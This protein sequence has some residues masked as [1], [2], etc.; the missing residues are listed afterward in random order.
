MSRRMLGLAALALAGC[1][2]LAGAGRPPET[3]LLARADALAAEGRYQDALE[4]YD[5]WLRQHPDGVEARR[6][7]VSRETIAALVDARGEID[8]L[9]RQLDEVARLRNQLAAR[10]SEL[11]RARAELAAARDGGEA[12]RLRGELAARDA[13]VARLR[14]ELA[15]LTAEADRLRAD[16]E[17]LKRVDLEMERG[18]R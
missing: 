11:A 12:A 5:Q 8:R 7:R 10:E 18:R 9:R 3:A 1:A 2:S 15:R 6:V 17:T 13:E 16:L 4:A 14:Q